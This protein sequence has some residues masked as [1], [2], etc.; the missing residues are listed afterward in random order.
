LAAFLAGPP[1]ALSQP[2]PYAAAE[3][4]RVTELL[5]GNFSSQEQSK[6]D[7]AYFDVR[8]HMARIWPER[9]GEHWIYVEQAMASTPEKPY[10]QRVYRVVW[11]NGG[12]VSLVYTLPGDPLKFA[13]AWKTPKPLSDLK[14]N[15][16][17]ERD[18]CAI[19]LK[20]Q[21]DG[22]YVG[23]TVGQGCRSELGMAKY[24]TSEVTLSRDVLA[25]WDRGF[26]A[27]GKQVW[28]ATKGPYLFR[29]APKSP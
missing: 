7:N 15:D 8:L 5:V 6:K 4:D 19:V 1:E 22:T 25:T 14:P 21:S 3:L 24:A 23:S 2:T 10:R 16:L 27:N 28:G 20:K 9:S 17:T 18:G 11:R 29:R 13:G 26:D 12:P